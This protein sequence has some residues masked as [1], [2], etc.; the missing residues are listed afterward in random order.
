MNIGDKVIFKPDSVCGIVS[1]VLNDDEVILIE[2][3]DIFG[4][5]SKLRVN[6]RYCV[7]VNIDHD[8]GI[9]DLINTL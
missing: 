4:K 6:K 1:E 8:M 2:C 3:H 9:A 7:V 5:R